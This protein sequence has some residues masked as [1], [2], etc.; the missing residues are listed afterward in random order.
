MHTSCNNYVFVSLL[1][2]DVGMSSPQPEPIDD[3]VDV[4]ALVHC[5]AA[6]AAP[7]NNSGHDVVLCMWSLVTVE[8]KQPMYNKLFF[9]SK[10]TSASPAQPCFELGVS[11]SLLIRTQRQNQWLEKG[12]QA[13][14]AL[15]SPTSGEK[16]QVLV[17]STAARK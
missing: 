12:K 5:L 17:D 8:G 7:R 11:N 15:E 9:Y 3:I 1:N 10:L 4:Q 14:V 16:E 2:Q 6:A 13:V